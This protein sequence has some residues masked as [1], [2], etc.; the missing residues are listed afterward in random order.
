MFLWQIRLLFARTVIVNLFLP[1]ANKLFTKKRDFKTNRKG[2]PNVEEQK[3][4]K[5]EIIPITVHAGSVKT[6]NN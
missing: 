1:K 4:S 3:N 5:E 2:A 6:G